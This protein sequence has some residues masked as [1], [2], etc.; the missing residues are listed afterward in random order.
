[1]KISKSM[2]FL[3]ILTSSHSLFLHSS[4]NPIIKTKAIKNEDLAQ[5][6]LLISAFIKTK[7]NNLAKKINNEYIKSSV[8]STI[9]FE[10]KEALH[11]QL[12]KLLNTYITLNKTKSMTKDMTGKYKYSIS[13]EDKI[14]NSE[15]ANTFLNAYDEIMAIEHQA[16]KWPIALDQDDLNTIKNKELLGAVLF[17]P[18]IT[19]A[20]FNKVLSFRFSLAAAAK[21]VQSYPCENLQANAQSFFDG[22]EVRTK[23]NLAAYDFANQDDINN[24]A[25]IDNACQNQ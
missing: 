6:K 10:E 7:L 8:S 17:M 21:N 3:S 12:N 14:I 2:L 11:D 16:E 24:K 5:K 22:L 19:I 4:G 25:I 23:D 20:D 9:S 18:D 1:M 13:H 15:E